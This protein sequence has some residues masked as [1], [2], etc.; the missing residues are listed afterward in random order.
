MEKL[1]ADLHNHTTGSDGTQSPLMFLLRAFNR[2]YKIVSMSDHDSV[3]GYTK[4]INQLQTIITKL[5]ENP[6]DKESRIGAMRLLKVL[7][8]LQLLPAAELLTKYKA[9]NN[10]HASTIEI[11]GYGADPELLGEN[12]KKIHETLPSKASLNYPGVVTIVKELGLD[13]FDMFYID[14]RNDYRKLFYHEICKYPEN[15]KYFED[16]EGETEEERAEAF[17][18]KYIDN[19]NSPFYVDLTRNDDSTKGPIRQGKEIKADFASMFERTKDILKFNSEV[20]ANAGAVIGEF[21][22]EL[23]RHPEYR[24]LIAPENNTMKKFIYGEIYN[25]HS[26]FYIDTAP[27]RPTIKATIEAIHDSG[28]MAFLAHPGRY[29]ELFD[30]KKEIEEGTLFEGLDGVEVFYP[31]H[32]ESFIQYLLERCNERGLDVSGGSDD[33]LAPKDGPIYKMGAV[34]VPDIP[35]TQWIKTCLKDGKYFLGETI[36]SNEYGKRL[37]KI[38]KETNLENDKNEQQNTDR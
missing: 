25:E 35:E 30:V 13:D 15:K 1:N 27:S 28:G 31:A 3:D 19:P 5:E 6:D 4:L 18:A 14:N 7:T 36:K 32:D 29:E 16:I 9:S 24:E 10:E 2:G 17:S 33:H 23:I 38:I 12:I 22:T 37:M 34:N 20:I 26:K 8:S 11:L 21:Y